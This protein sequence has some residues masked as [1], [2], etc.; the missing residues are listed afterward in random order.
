[1]IFQNFSILI[2]VHKVINKILLFIFINIFIKELK[3]TF[4][5]YTQTQTRT[6]HYTHNTTLT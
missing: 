3:H 4:F 5:N 1:M 2:I 6:Y